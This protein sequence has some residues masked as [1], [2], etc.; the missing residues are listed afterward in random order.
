M[1]LSDIDFS[2]PSRIALQAAME[3]SRKLDMAAFEQMCEEEFTWESPAFEDDCWVL[4]EDQSTIDIEMDDFDQ[5]PRFHGWTIDMKDNSGMEV[6]VELLAWHG[7]T[8]TYRVRV[9]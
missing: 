1:N 2:G 9:V 8:A 7:T 5:I 3:R 4:H 6:R